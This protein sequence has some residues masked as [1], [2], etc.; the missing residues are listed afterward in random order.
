MSRLSGMVEHLKLTC[1]QLKENPNHTWN[2]KKHLYQ[3]DNYD[4]N[5][6]GYVS[7]YNAQTDSRRFQNSLDILR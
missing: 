1:K 2:N 6:H 7:Y 5:D 4:H 3:K